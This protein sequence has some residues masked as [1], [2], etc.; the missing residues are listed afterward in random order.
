MYWFKLVKYDSQTK[1]EEVGQSIHL[2]LLMSK[3]DLN[4]D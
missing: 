2:S 4:L 3:P 1:M